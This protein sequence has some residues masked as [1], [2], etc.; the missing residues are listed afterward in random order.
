[1]KLHPGLVVRINEK[2]VA[3]V[4][5]ENLNII[6]VRIHGDVLSQEIAALD[7]TG[8]YYGEPETRHMLWVADHE[9]SEQDEIEIQFL[10]VV[11]NSHIGKTI[12]ELHPESPVSEGNELI[13]MAELAKELEEEPR[14]R[15]GFDLHVCASGAEPQVFKVREPDYSFFVSVMWTWESMDSAKL[16]ISSTTIQGIVDRKRGTEYLRGRLGRG[17]SIRVRVASD[18]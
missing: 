8:G 15:S 1:M 11:E 3:S 14:V 16:G 5:S 9:I 18:H 17:H 13:D 6:A 12:E 7:V 10:E 4:S 2:V